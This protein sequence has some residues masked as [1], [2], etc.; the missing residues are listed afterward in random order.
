MDIRQQPAQFNSSKEI[1]A[2]PVSQA[3]IRTMN[4][5]LRSLEQSGGQEPQPFF[6]EINPPGK[7]A[8]TVGK[9]SADASPEKS[10]PEIAVRKSRWWLIVILAV[11]LTALLAG[12][13]YLFLRFSSARNSTSGQ[14]V[15]KPLVGAPAIPSAILQPAASQSA[16]SSP[17]RISL[18]KKPLFGRAEVV[19]NP[20]SLDNLQRSLLGVASGTTAG[21]LKE[22][23]FQDKSFA[24]ISWPQFLSL[25]LSEIRPEQTATIFEE[26]FGAAIFV[27]KNNVWPGYAAKLKPN[28]TLIQAHSLIKEILE[29]P[30][31]A[32]N[33][34]LKKPGASAAEF[35]D[36]KIGNPPVSVRC[37]DFSQTG[38]NFCYGWLNNDLLL[39][40]TST[41]TLSALLEKI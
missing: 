38:A 39:M 19:L 25:I 36:N 33:F 1:S 12:G 2:P 11:V 27:D 28:I 16:L 3:K 30:A 35:Q 37:L 31:A 10:E 14:L 7:K 18:F 24:P 13:I 5:D 21:V 9:P 22:I 15:S 23:V 26:N 29:E 40:T 8:E 6:I 34:F 20:F 41:S 4:S 17:K 32:P